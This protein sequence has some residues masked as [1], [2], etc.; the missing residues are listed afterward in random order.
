[1]LALIGFLLNCN[2][3]ASAYGGYISANAPE[4]VNI[5]RSFNVTLTLDS[6][7]PVKSVWIKFKFDSEYISFSKVSS[8]IKADTYHNTNDGE[9]EV[10]CLFKDAVTQ[11]D[12]VSMTFTAKTG[13]ES[14]TQTIFIEIVDAVANDLE[15]ADLSGDESV[16]VYIERKTSLSQNESTQKKSSYVSH[17]STASKKAVTSSKNEIQSHKDNISSVK[18]Y[19]TTHNIETTS[20]V[21][22]ENE[23]NY[24]IHSQITSE[25]LNYS[26]SKVKYILSGA[27]GTICVIG[28]LFG[29][30]KLGETKSRSTYMKQNKTDTKEYTD[31]DNT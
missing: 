26:D 2:I 21:T 31:S 8:P 27:G 1:M 20:S 25:K 18:K 3:F 6:S 19:D 11:S 13:N 28:V 15:K 30:Y 7:K 10:I 12:I 14:S 9:A 22:E 5:G 29:V 4:T 24:E 23:L 16:E 17:S